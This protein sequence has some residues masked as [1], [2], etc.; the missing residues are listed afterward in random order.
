[1]SLRKYLIDLKDKDK[2]VKPKQILLAPAVTKQVAEGILQG[3]SYLH[4]KRIAHRDIKADNVLINLSGLSQIKSIHL[5]DFGISRAVEHTL[6]PLTIGGTPGYMS[7]EM[8]AY[9][10]GKEKKGSYDPFKADM[11]A[12]G[13]T[14]YECVT[15]ETPQPKVSIPKE[16]KDK[17]YDI[18]SKMFKAC[19]KTNPQH[20]PTC[21]ALFSLINQKIEEQEMSLEKQ[22]SNDEHIKQELKTP[23]TEKA[24]DLS[25]AKLIKLIA[26]GDNE[27]QHKL[28]LLSSFITGELPEYIPTVFEN[29]NAQIN[30]NGKKIILS[31]WDTAGQEDYDRLR[32]LAYPSTDVVLL[33]FSTISQASYDAIRVKWTPEL[34]HYLPNIPVV[35]VGTNIDLREAQV[36]DPHS[37]KYDPISYE[38]GKAMAAEIGARKYMEVSAKTHQGVD[39]L[40]NEAVD[41]VLQEERGKD[42]PISTKKEQVNKFGF[43]PKNFMSKIFGK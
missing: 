8:L 16:K 41:I 24:I 17:D 33:C 21:E 40:F 19:T 10:L 20:R 37:G 29:Y 23:T 35:L 5:T 25:Y 27:E 18:V 36:P 28:T 1:M 22:L 6:C 38:Q 39:E 4:A 2:W 43:P 7:P 11:Y 14:L 42:V 26:V 13:M 3:L 30:R 32:Q 31:L 12:F 9:L 34:Q 15:G